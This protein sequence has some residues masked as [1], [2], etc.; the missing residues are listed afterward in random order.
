[1]ANEDAA[2][3]AAIPVE[4]IGGPV[5]L[6]SSTG[7]EM[8]PATRMSRRL[9]SRLEANGFAHPHRHVEVAGGHT[10]VVDHFEVVEEFLATVVSSRS[11]CRSERTEPL[12]P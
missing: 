12:S 11:G 10:A 4:R 5:L 8:W 7:D 2:A 3:A 1:L 9:I 6:I